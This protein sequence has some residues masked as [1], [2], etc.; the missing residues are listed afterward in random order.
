[1]KMYRIA[2]IALA[3][4][5]AA[6]GKPSP[7]EVTQLK[8]D[9]KVVDIQ[10][11]KLAEVAAPLRALCQF[12]DFAAN[13]ARERAQA[14]GTAAV[15]VSA[16]VGAAAGVL[17]GRPAGMQISRSEQQTTRSGVDGPSSMVT[18]TTQLA[19]GEFI[20]D[21]LRKYS[22]ATGK[23]MDPQAA[24]AL[25]ARLDALRAGWRVAT[26]YHSDTALQEALKSFDRYTYLR[27]T[28]TPERLECVRESAESGQP[29][30]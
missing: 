29:R 1:M 19:L 28:F 27:V 11:E 2:G 13:R 3:A 7:R 5:V 4:L 16:V 9:D 10:A 14:S 24:V 20:P 23:P 30:R 22:E 18:V 15:S 6:C 8:L 17:S 25:R 26:L 12:A 21:E